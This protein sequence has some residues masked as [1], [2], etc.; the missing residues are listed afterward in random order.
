MCVK[1]I[2]VRTC[3]FF[4]A[5]L[6]LFLKEIEKKYEIVEMNIKQVVLNKRDP[7]FLKSKRGFL[8]VISLTYQPEIY[9]N[10]FVLSC[11]I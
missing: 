1:K 5:C 8:K 3:H 10:L 11:F 9:Y 4:I 6:L 7:R 2:D